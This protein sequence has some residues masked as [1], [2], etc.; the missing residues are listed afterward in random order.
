M[1]E[2][3]VS[4]S[5]GMSNILYKL[6][7]G[8]HSGGFG[9]GI[10]LG[11]SYNVKRWLA[12]VTGFGVSVYNSKLTM[13]SHSGEYNG[14]DDVY[15][16][17]TFNYSLRGYSEKQNAILFTV[18][19][20]A[21]YSTGLGAG[22]LRYYVAGGLKVGIPVSAGASTASETVTTSGYYVFEYGTYTG[23]PNRG[24]VSD[25]AGEQS[26]GKIKLDVVPLLAL[27]TGIRFPVGYKK[28]LMAGVYLDCSPGDIRKSHNRHIVEYQPSN[29]S[30][31]VH[32]SIINTPLLK[33]A[34][35]F[36][37][38]LKIGLNF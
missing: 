2:L 28:D 25:V 23:L 30:L 27:E 8:S 4:V 31:F 20:M 11:Y 22:A 37:A 6:D 10:D 17:F 26:D 13:D 18:P 7:E 36:S 35:L 14:F 38:G 32:N 9:G 34:N 5:A 16:E 15:D 1:H 24:F 12:I 33:K 19:V 21:R 29:P 3:S